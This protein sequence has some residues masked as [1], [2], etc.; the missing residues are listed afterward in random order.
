M[1]AVLLHESARHGGVA[2]RNRYEIGITVRPLSADEQDQLAH[3]SALISGEYVAVARIG[4]TVE[5]AISEGATD[6]AAQAA[7]KAIGERVRHGDL[8]VEE[9]DD[10]EEDAS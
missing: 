6:A 7:A 2:M 1:T 3:V 8:V 5:W 9:D 10:V 4:N